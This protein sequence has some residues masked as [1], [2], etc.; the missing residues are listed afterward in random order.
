[1]KNNTSELKWTNQYLTDQRLS[2]WLFQ[3]QTDIY[4][5]IKSP[6][7]DSISSAVSTATIIY[8]YYF[9]LLIKNDKTVKRFDSIFNDLN[10]EIKQLRNQSE[11]GKVSI[12]YDY[13]SYVINVISE[14]SRVVQAGNYFF[15]V[16]I[17]QKRFS[18]ALEELDN[19]PGGVRQ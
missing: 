18:T 3:H 19:L 6:T 2:N 15:N 4:N 9:R 17:D 12:K 16:N 7:L 5:A 8:Y 1:M 14:L 13:V 10:S 11:R